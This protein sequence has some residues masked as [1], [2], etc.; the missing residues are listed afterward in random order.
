MYIKN[1]Y[2]DKYKYAR[3]YKG[4]IKILQMGDATEGRIMPVQTVGQPGMIIG[5]I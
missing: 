3:S 1:R 5:I 4:I 2:Y